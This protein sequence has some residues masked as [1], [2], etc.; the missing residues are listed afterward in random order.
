MRGFALAA[1]AEPSLF[2]VA[3]VSEEMEHQVA[4]I[5][6][7]DAVSSAMKEFKPDIVF[8]MAAHPLVGFSY[9]SPVETYGTNVMGTV[10]VLDYALRAGSARA[11]VNI[12][13]DKCYENREWLW[14]DREDEPMGGLDPYSSSKGSDELFSLAY[15]KSFLQEANIAMATVRAG[16]VIGGGDRA[17]DR[18]I[19]DILRVVDSERS[20]LVRNPQAVRPLQHFLEPIDGC[21]SLAERLLDAGEAYAHS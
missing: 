16:I 10:D 14:G 11:I 17:E 5:R 19:P 6:N 21:L 1:P 8:Y 18:L 9:H 12:T 4:D 3:C 15:R 20:V 13:I 2:N 7:Y